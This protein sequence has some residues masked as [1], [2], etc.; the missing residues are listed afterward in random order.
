MINLGLQIQNENGSRTFPYY[1]HHLQGQ[2]LDRNQ[3]LLGWKEVPPH[4]DATR[5]HCPNE[6]IKGREE[7]AR[8]RGYRQRRRVPLLRPGLRR[9]LHQ[10]KG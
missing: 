9:L 4:Q 7:R 10:A 8:V 3:K 2:I 6:P 1:C 5:M